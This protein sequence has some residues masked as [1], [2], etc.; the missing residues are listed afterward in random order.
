MTTRR[1]MTTIAALALLS[2]GGRL[3][4]YAWHARTAAFM[5]MLG[6]SFVVL[7]CAVA[8]AVY[9][10]SKDGG[11]WLPSVWPALA[12]GVLSALLAVGVSTYVERTYGWALFVLVPFVIGLHATLALSRRRPIVLGEALVVSSLALLFFGGVLLAVAVEGLICLLMAAPIALPMALLG[13]AA[14]YALRSRSVVHSPPM[15]LLLAGLTP[16]GATAERALHLS[17]EIFPVTTSIDLP[18]S[19]ERVWRTVVQ[20]A[21]LAPPKQP[22]FRAGVAYPLA[23]H[24]EGAGPQA[25][26][27]CDFSTGKLIEPVLVWDDLH[28]LRFRVASNPLPMQEWT[29]YARLHPPHLEGFLVSRE[30]EFRL[31]PLVNGGTRLYATTWYQHHL[32]PARYWKLWSDYIIHQ[33]H[34]MVLENI[35]QRAAA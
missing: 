23:S 4:Y 2:N 26:R 24:I 12:S 34:G 14:G 22:L 33:I 5:A 9:W 32:W 29:P 35:A 21:K 27:Y 18:A 11:R 31:E 6:I 28:R 16:W 15:F 25:T 10:S 30:G 19:P 17:A 8:G 7:I 13:G 1:V 3:F 20:P